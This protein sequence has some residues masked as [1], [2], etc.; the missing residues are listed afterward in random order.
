TQVVKVTYKSEDPEF[1][2]KAV[3]VLADEYMNFGLE[4]KRESIRQAR[5][6]LQEELTKLQQK[7][8]QSEQRL[9]DY[10]RAHNML[11]SQDSNVIV[12]KVTELSD[13][14]TKV[15]AEVMANP[16][17]SLQNTPIE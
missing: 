5:D 16:Y 9:V 11:P 14:V 7:L 13:Q 17:E 10:S 8:Q 12:R 6:F 15:E 4:T 3:N 1:A 2:A